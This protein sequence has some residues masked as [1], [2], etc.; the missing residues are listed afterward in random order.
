[1]G[2]SAPASSNGE[3]ALI[4]SELGLPEVAAIV[5]AQLAERHIAVSIVGGSAVTLHAPDIYT[6]VDIDLAVLTGIDRKAIES[7]LRSL[8]YQRTGRVFQH[9]KSRF[10]IDIVADTPYIADRPITEFAEINTEFGPV[11]TLLLEDALADRVAA[12]LFWSDSQS[13]DVAERVV[14]ARTNALH[15]DRLTSTLE[16]LDATDPASA[17][18]LSFAVERLR[19]AYFA[20]RPE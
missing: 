18:R 15:W 5:S 7:A 3:A 4:T 20:Q 6:S 1:M 13:L 9:P 19:R 12:F 10:T 17:Q 11:R 16:A 8:G 2:D 14:R